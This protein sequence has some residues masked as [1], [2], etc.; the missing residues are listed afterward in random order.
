[1]SRE[2]NAARSRIRMAW[3][4]YHNPRC[5]KSRETLEI[6]RA[7]RIEPRVVEYLK[8]P[9]SVEEL[10]AILTM[11]GREPRDVMRKGESE[12]A[13]L[14]LDDPRLTRAE[15]VRAMVE[16]PVLIERPIV[17]KGKKAVIGRPPERVREML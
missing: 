13:E 3:T 9:P 14:K 8:T 2:R 6:L 4:I 5:S 12:Y 15:L 17:V 10:D 11:L 16:H 1:M 7:A